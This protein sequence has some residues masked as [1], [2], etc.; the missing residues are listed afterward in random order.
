MQSQLQ[1]VQQVQVASAAAGAFA[2]I[3]GDGSVVTW[4]DATL[5]GD[6]TSAQSQ[7]TNEQQVQAS[8][9]TFAALLGNALLGN[10]SVVTWGDADLGGGSSALQGQLSRST[11]LMVLSL[12]SLAM[13]PL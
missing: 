6:S 2:A 12:P 5:G 13:D 9:Q 3:F 10:G 1:E 8:A 4:G 7:L 11:A